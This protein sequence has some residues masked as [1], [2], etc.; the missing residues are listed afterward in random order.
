[1]SARQKSF[2]L[3]PAWQA[4]G[5]QPAWAGWRPV[6]E[7]GLARQDET[8]RLETGSDRAGDTTAYRSRTKNVEGNRREVNPKGARLSPPRE[9]RVLVFTHA[10]VRPLTVANGFTRLPT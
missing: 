2:S 8:G 1:M 10:R 3:R 6:G 7:R 5:L 4:Q 9:I